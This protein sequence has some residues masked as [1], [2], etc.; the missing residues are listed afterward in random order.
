MWNARSAARTNASMLVAWVRRNCRKLLSVVGD[1]AG[2]IQWR[3]DPPDRRAHAM[4][5]LE[6][7]TL[8]P[9]IPPARVLRRHPHH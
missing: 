9:H 2:G 4:A 8:D 6:Q 5:E 3:S 1:G 7:L